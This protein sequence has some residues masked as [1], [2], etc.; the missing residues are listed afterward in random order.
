MRPLLIALALLLASC[1]PAQ[2]AKV[3]STLTTVAGDIKSVASG[4][5][6]AADA[7]CADALPVIKTV[8][9]LVGNAKV[10]NLVSYATSICS[11]AGTV[12]AGASINA[13]TA[14]WIGGIKAGLNAAA[15]LTL[16]V[17]AAANATVAAPAAPATP[18]SIAP[19]GA[20]AA[21]PVVVSVPAASV[22][23]ASP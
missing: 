8:G 22:P 11:P 2:Q 10:T 14:S 23:A 16:P 7:A 18:V 20:P 21:S 17:A 12:V 13:T 15:N 19:T 3:Q 4:I 5:L 6:A 1:N 9:G